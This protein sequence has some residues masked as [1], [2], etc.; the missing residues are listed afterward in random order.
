MLKKKFYGA[1]LLGALILAACPGEPDP[2]TPQEPT[3]NK[4]EKKDEPVA[5]VWDGGVVSA[6]YDGGAEV[7]SEPVETSD[8][9]GGVSSFWPE[10]ESLFPITGQNTINE[11][12]TGLSG[13]SCFFGEDQFLTLH[14]AGLTYWHWAGLSETQTDAPAGALI[15]CAT[16]ED[17]APIL[18][19]TETIW[20]FDGLFWDVSPLAAV[21]DDR[22][23]HE[24][25]H[26]WRADVGDAFFFAFETG[27]YY[28][29]DGMFYEVEVGDV[30]SDQ[31][32]L[33]SGHIRVEGEDRGMGV[34]VSAGD[35]VYALTYDDD[36]FTA[37]ILVDD[38]SPDA[39]TTF[40]DHGLAMVHEGNLLIH[41]GDT[42]MHYALPDALTSVWGHN[43]KMD[44]F[45]GDDVPS[46]WLRE[47]GLLLQLLNLSSDGQW[48]LD[49]VGHLVLSRNDGLFRQHLVPY[50]RWLGLEQDAVLQDEAYVALT[51]GGWG[52]PTE[53]EVTLNEVP[54]ALD[55][56]DGVALVLAQPNPD[57][58]QTDN[59]GNPLISPTQLFDGEQTLRARIVF[60]DESEVTRSLSFVVGEVRTPT[61]V[62]DVQ[63]MYQTRCAQC[64][65]EGSNTYVLH[66]LEHWQANFDT[67]YLAL[68]TA[69]MPLP[70]GDN[71]APFTDLELEILTRWQAAG[72][73]ETMDDVVEPIPET[74]FEAEV[75]PLFEAHCA[76][77]HGAEGGARNL[78]SASAWEDDIDNIISTLEDG[79]MPLGADP[80][81]ASDVDL[82]KA[83]R[84]GGF[85]P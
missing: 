9:D 83:W 6:V 51:F 43:G 5:P 39:I 1:Y 32:R 82:L 20:I 3:E 57:N 40:G 48:M 12:L 15:H 7:P 14:D 58:W 34:W 37:Y 25:A 68:E 59:D 81:P 61:W 18:F 55:S 33:R 77:C 71:D 85:L 65:Y 53:V 80:L 70:T 8:P 24:V 41:D 22:V 62:D 27:L 47:D 64:H 29:A 35:W 16:L 49:A 38:F 28:W 36:D 75:K 74:S 84:D 31:A 10:P 50:A 52:L 78:E 69:Q 4:E 42:R 11:T 46:W 73:P 30:P 19:T 44:L 23:L 13:Q 60:E 45:M 79:V 67:I 66:D 72:F 76:N 21:L 54:F 2:E 63:V 17:G 26:L 56:S